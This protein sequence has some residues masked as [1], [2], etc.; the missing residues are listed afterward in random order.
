MKY[1]YLNFSIS[2]SM[3]EEIVYSNIGMK[4]TNNQNESLEG[5]FR[6]EEVRKWIRIVE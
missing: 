6:C 5:S 1:K 3:T 2:T 4:V